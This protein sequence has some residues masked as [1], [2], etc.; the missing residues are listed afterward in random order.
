MSESLRFEDPRADNKSGVRN[1]QID[2]WESIWASEFQGGR[3]LQARDQS[4]HWHL[5]VT[6]VSPLKQEEEKELGHLLPLI[7]LFL[8]QGP[9]Q[10]QPPED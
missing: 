10:Q 7:L 8:T 2:F 9:L 1:Q 6:Q 3:C 5:S 4:L